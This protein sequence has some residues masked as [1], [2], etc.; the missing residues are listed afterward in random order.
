MRA[1]G[2]WVCLAL[3]DFV[4]RRAML[5]SWDENDSFTVWIIA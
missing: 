4:F 2:F 1:F 3:D 5:F